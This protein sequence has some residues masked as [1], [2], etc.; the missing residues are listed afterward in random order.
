MV[1]P[2]RRRAADRTPVAVPD[3]SG[4]VDLTLA[5]SVDETTMPVVPVRADAALRRIVDVA[6]AVAVL[7]VLWPVLVA[8]GVA[9]RATSPGPAL[10]RQERVGRGGRPF[11]VLKFRTMVDDADR[12]G[13]LV[14]GSHD[15]RVTRVGAPLR[16]TRLDELPQVLN[17]LRG[18][19]TLIGP[20]P[21]VPRYVA[22]YRPDERAVLDVRPGL[23]GAG[24]VCFATEHADA[25]DA[26][27]DPEEHYLTHQL[28]PKLALDLDYLRHRS[29]RRDL[30]ILLRTLVIVARP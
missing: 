13:A 4:G 24:Q 30:G 14:S 12:T 27:S 20:R 6:V 22:S 21:E 28:H 23:T 1:I 5:P 19:M 17:M 25:L 8:V 26:V 7:L 10:Y 29:L 18:D 15:P 16:A 2:S 3:P 11:R 9:I